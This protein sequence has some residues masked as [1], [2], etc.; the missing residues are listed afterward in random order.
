ME[1]KMIITVKNGLVR[2]E[3]VDFALS[4]EEKE[5]VL[6]LILTANMKV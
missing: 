4:P 2:L 5:G 6:R 3:Y 1:G